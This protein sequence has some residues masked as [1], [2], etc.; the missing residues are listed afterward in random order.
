MVFL[1]FIKELQST[2]RKQSSIKHHDSPSLIPNIN[3]VTTTTATIIKIH[4]DDDNNIA[5]NNYAEESIYF[6]F[7]SVT[8]ENSQK[9][10]NSLEK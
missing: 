2:I 7:T 5:A 8:N 6:L 9:E 10:T 1:Y 4:N 3:N